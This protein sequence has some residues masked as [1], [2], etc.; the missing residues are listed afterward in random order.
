M[1]KG[2]HA[3]MEEGIMSMLGDATGAAETRPAKERRPEP[4]GIV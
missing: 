2:E 3:W 4:A 1:L